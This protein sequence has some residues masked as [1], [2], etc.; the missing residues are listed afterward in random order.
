MTDISSDISVSC[1]LC[2]YAHPS[3]HKKFKKRKLIT[4][5]QNEYEIDITEILKGIDQICEFV[6]PRCDLIFFFPPSLAAPSDLYGQLEK[7][8]W[9]YLPRKWEHDLAIQSMRTGQRVLEIGCGEGDFVSR[10]I[11]KGIYAEGIELNTKAVAKARSRGL[12][13]SSQ[14]LADAAIKFPESFDVICS[15][16]VLEHVPN[17]SEFIS[18]CCDLLVPGGIL[19]FGLPNA[20]SFLKHQFNLLDL[21]P[22]HMTRWAEQAL[23][24]IT[25]L[26]PL[27]LL[28]ISFEPLASY[29]VDGFVKANCEALIG[30]KR[31]KGKFFYLMQRL[32]IVMMQMTRLHK[33]FIGQTLYVSYRKS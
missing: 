24:F 27:Q 19:I 7:Y 8:P 16:Q 32:I 30:V 17:P 4:S 5:W 31:S 11:N 22:H 29:H 1:P 21:P 26:F 13:I 12:P 9:Y 18:R 20:S 2:G 3:L 33:L 6:C 25:N 10:M 15:F 28:E 14:N 23:R